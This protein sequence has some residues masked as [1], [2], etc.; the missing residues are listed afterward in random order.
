MNA[1]QKHTFCYCSVLH[2]R[3]AGEI[4]VQLAG[5]LSALILLSTTMK[6]KIKSQ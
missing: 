5:G 2:L 6:L 4:K 1:E 3:R